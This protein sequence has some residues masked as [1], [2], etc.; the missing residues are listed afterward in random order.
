VKKIALLLIVFIFVSP[1]LFATEKDLGAWLGMSVSSKIENIKV[2]VEE[3]FRFDNSASSLAYAHTDMGAKVRLLRGDVLK[4]DS[5]FNFRQV[6]TKREKIYER[7]DR[8]HL[9]FELRALL[10]KSLETSNRLRLEA[11]FKDD[12]SPRWRNR[13][14]IKIN[15]ERQVDLIISDE[16]FMS[17]EQG[18]QKNR[19][20]AGVD[21]RVHKNIFLLP[22]HV[23][24]KSTLSSDH[25]FGFYTKLSF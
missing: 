15:L 2:R 19:I 9:S 4:L 18:I 5:S 13:L 25:I 6:Y 3:E 21:I 7:E 1:E 14:G 8:P 22:F 12:L 24:E 23:W 17:Y 10:W 20:F 11:R 16:I